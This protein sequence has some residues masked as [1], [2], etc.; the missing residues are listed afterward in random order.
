MTNY[1]YTFWALS[2]AV[3]EYPPHIVRTEQV[4]RKQNIF[5]E[6]LASW[7]LYRYLVPVNIPYAMFMHEVFLLKNCCCFLSLIY[8]KN[9][10][11]IRYP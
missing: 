1:T 9:N 6:K 4:R 8:L 3:C 11:H 7:P 2:C 10:G 5:S